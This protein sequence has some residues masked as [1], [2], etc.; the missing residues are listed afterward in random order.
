MGKLVVF[1]VHRNWT[2]NSND[3]TGQ[4]KLHKE[5]AT[6]LHKLVDKL[7]LVIK[8]WGYTDDTGP[9]ESVMISVSIDSLKTFNE[10]V[11]AFDSTISKRK[12]LKVEIIGPRNSITVLP[13]DDKKKLTKQIKSLK[14]G[15]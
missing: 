8:D 13:Y 1:R 3:Y 2:E 6:F 9:H 11:D 12:L 14:L 5:R 15:K 10:I 7:K 4:L